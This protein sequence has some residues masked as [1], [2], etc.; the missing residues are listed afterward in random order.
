ML[1][2]RTPNEFF[3]NFPFR[4][5]RGF[6][7]RPIS[8]RSMELSDDGLIMDIGFSKGA[9]VKMFAVVVN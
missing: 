5:G 1:V 2:T 8:F 7:V 6:D 4:W 9:L 3:P